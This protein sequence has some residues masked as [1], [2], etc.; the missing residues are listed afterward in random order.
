MNGHGLITFADGS[1][2]RPRNEGVFENAKIIRREKATEA[3]SKAQKS[4]ERAR[5]VRQKYDSGD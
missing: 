3:I 5:E 1:H 4:S 2:G